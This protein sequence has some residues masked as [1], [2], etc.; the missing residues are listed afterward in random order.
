MD[1]A[2]YKLTAWLI[3]PLLALAGCKEK[4]SDEPSFVKV[5]SNEVQFP[6]KGGEQTISIES[7]IKSLRTTIEY[8]SKDSEGWL[9]SSFLTNRLVLTADENDSQGPREAKVTLAG[10]GGSA[11]ITVKQAGAGY[12][13]I[14]NPAEI[15]V[16]SHST[17]YDI[18]LE[19]NVEY[20]FD[21]EKSSEWISVEKQEGVDKEGAWTLLISSNL[22]E[23]TREGVAVFSSTN[24]GQEASVEIK[25]T[26]AAATEYKGVQGAIKGDF[27]IKIVS[28]TTTS[29]QRN[30]E[31]EKSFDGDYRTIYHSNWSNGGS[32]Y[33][34][35]TIEYTLEEAE[36]IDY[37]VYHPRQ[38]GSPNG[39]FG[40]TEIWV[41]KGNGE[42][43]KLLDYDFKQSGTPTRIDFKE[44]LKDVK[45]FRFVVKNGG[46]HAQGFAAISEMEFFRINHEEKV[47]LNVF[48]DQIASSLKAGVTEEEIKAIPN[49]LFRELAYFMYA[50][51]YDTEFRVAE[52]RAWPHPQISAKNR[53]TWPQNLLDNPTGIVAKKGEEL[54][55]FVGPTHGYEL[56]IKIQNLDA[57]GG[58]G[59]GGCCSS[60]YPVYEGLNV[61][62]PT[63]DG[64]IYLFYHTPQWEQA[65]KIKIHFPTGEVNGYFDSQKHQKEDWK[66]LLAG[67]KYKYFDVLGQYTH[68][69]FPT[70]GFRRYA[71][72]DGPELIDQY[73]DMVY[74]IRDFIGLHKYN[75]PVVNRSYF[76]AV[77]QSYLYATTYRTCYNVTTDAVLKAMCHRQTYRQSPWGHAH[78]SGHTYQTRPN[79]TWVGMAEVTNNIYALYIQ[80]QWGNQSRLLSGNKY[81]HAFNVYL[82]DR[83]D[84]KRDWTPRPYIYSD[85]IYDHVF[86]KLV[87]LWQL[88]LYMTKVKGDEDF[89]KDL[90]EKIRLRPDQNDH[91]KAQ[92]EFTE[93]ACETAGLDL[94]DFF[95]T[96]NFYVQ[97]V[98]KA[99]DYGE[100]DVNLNQKLIEETKARIKAKGYPK[101]EHAIHYIMDNNIDLF[102]NNTPVTVGKATITPAK[103]V[104]VK[105][106]NGATAYEVELDGK[107]IFIFYQQGEAFGLP[108]KATITDTSKLKVFAI[109]ST[110]TRTEVPIVPAGE[111]N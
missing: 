11:T 38:D 106:V 73:D 40:E 66:R 33:W 5:S 75:R 37:M 4:P 98:G 22:S 54:I 19:S 79:F 89:Y 8:I 71:Q 25:V 111:F 103:E 70:D 6:P 78:E 29:F 47:P 58:D 68:I 48:A 7:N 15:N 100:R 63:N 92:M 12:Y 86:E 96:W 30:E 81:A 14:A 44:P 53:K 93:I 65:P 91:A 42:F 77:Y 16:P 46:G 102:K 52:Y 49:A 76:H 39:N 110:G 97:Y 80:T 56:S 35:I 87:P 13:I 23:S 17:N 90:H 24:S 26:Q 21:A 3:L 18:A 107:V 94:T 105:G 69:T 59:Y 32:N 45:A 82:I 60:F 88:Q 41:K 67:A 72:N 50:G 28:G 83:S 84:I 104:K 27:R 64:L 62:T 36:H 74:K 101:P 2:I 51:K 57:P 95:E 34:P 109:S 85:E 108:E 20:A 43:Q 55:F 1:R 99:K 31:I 10:L 61:I 9:T